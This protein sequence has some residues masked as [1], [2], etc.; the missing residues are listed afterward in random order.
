M[1]LRKLKYEEY[2]DKACQQLAVLQDEFRT[3]YDIENYA[4]WFYD[5]SSESLRL[6]SDEKEIYFKYIP[7]GSFSQK[8]STWMWAWANEHSVEPSKYFTSKVKEFGEKKKYEKLTN[9]HFD[10]D[11]YTGWE[12]TSI[13]FDILGGIGTYRVIS[14]HLEIYFLLIGQISKEEVEEIEWEN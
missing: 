3:K 11:Q 1:I 6:Y 13:A 2:A 5:Q 12:L 9:A 14:G 8:T 4:N 10:G 7:V